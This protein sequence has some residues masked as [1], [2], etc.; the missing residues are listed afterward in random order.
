ML[1]GDSDRL[2]PSDGEIDSGSF[3][4]PAAITDTGCERDLNEDRYAV[5]ESHSGIAWLVCDGMGGSTGGELAAQLAI[6]AMRRNLENLPPRPPD[7]ALHSAIL[8]ANRIIVLRRQNQAFSQMGTTI[9]AAMFSG[10]EV[11]ISHVGDSRAYL[12]RDGA[13]EQLTTDH[14]YVQELVDKGKIQ[15][16]EALSHPQAHIL[17]RCIGS[18]P[19]LEIDSQKLWLW[20]KSLLQ[21]DEYNGNDLLVLLTDGLYSLVN[22]G[23][24]ANLVAQE[25]PQMACAKL[26]ELAKS[27]GGYDNISVAIVP[28]PGQLRKEPPPGFSEEKMLKMRRAKL[29]DA[30][31]RS[32]SFWK[33]MVGVLFLSMLAAL[34]VI[35]GVTITVSSGTKEGNGTVEK[36]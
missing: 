36:Q 10:P 31:E 21:G 33:T 4:V 26:V 8:E 3:D 7:A 14:T 18:E 27:R 11:V 30:E 2:K 23:E 35:L 6:D 19:A 25:T 17:T 16:E 34:V 20:E 29:L 22:E 1:L 9:V 12:V 24:I 13:I 15:P 28:L 32:R 5:I